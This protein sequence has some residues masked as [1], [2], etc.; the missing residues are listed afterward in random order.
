MAMLVRLA[1]WQSLSATSTCWPRPVR[2]RAS[3]AAST[4]LLVYRPVVRSV[5][6]TPTLTGG[7]SRSPVMCISPN[8][9]RRR[10]RVSGRRWLAVRLRGRGRE[11]GRERGQRREKAGS[12]RERYARF[13][14]DVVAGAVAVRPV[15]P[16]ARDAGVDERRIKRGD[17]G[18]VESVLGQAA[19]QVVLDEHVARR[20][21]LVQHRHA[22]R[23]RKRQAHGLFVAVHLFVPPSVGCFCV[24]QARAIGGQGMRGRGRGN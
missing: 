4:A 9:L 21:Q 7:P 5:I 10:S 16:V 13:N 14:H 23:V 3:S 11:E 6:A 1:I 19:R 17:A 20:R 12:R 18:I 8:S 22:G 2:A 24:K 15:L